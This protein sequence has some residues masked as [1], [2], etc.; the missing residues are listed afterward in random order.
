VLTKAE[1]LAKAQDNEG[2]AG[3]HDWADAICVDWTITYLFY[4]AVHY[5][6]AY[7]TRRGLGYHM[8]TA[9]NSAI[10]RDVAL[11]P[12]YDDYRELQNF[13][14]DARYERPTGSFRTAD[15]V[16][17]KECLERIKG[18]VMPLVT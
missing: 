9:R 1:H 8:H 3:R 5:V 11:R 13:S 14:R 16:Y 17:L 10:G 2:F 12:I 4:S 18:V 7:F 6:E 15:I